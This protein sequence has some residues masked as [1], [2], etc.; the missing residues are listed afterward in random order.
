MSRKHF[1]IFGL[2]CISLLLTGCGGNKLTCSCVD[3]DEERGERYAEYVIHY[4]EEWKKIESID[5]EYGYR[6]TDSEA[7]N[8]DE[9]EDD[10]K[11]SCNEDDA[12]KDCKVNL[13]GNNVYLTATA[14]ADTFGIDSEIS[15]DEMIEE[16]EEDDE[17][18]CSK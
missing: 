11:E 3:K 10:L 14:D 5:Y 17:C 12:P 18:S 8:I 9:Y 2:V 7:K 16:I 15:K 1:G 6:L 13:S 4:D